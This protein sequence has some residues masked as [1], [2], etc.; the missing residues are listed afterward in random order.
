MD[1]L[2]A[3]GIDHYV[4]NKVR[5]QTVFVFTDGAK[6]TYRPTINVCT[7][8]IY[9]K[10]YTCSHA[11]EVEYLNLHD[12]KHESFRFPFIKNE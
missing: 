8:A 2:E 6:V 11:V 4:K 9:L 7:C 12:G 10:H 1:Q 3:P 5:K